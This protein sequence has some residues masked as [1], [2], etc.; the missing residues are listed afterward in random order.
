M[1]EQQDFQQSIAK[2]QRDWQGHTERK[3]LY[4]GLILMG[5]ILSVATLLAP[6][7]AAWL[8]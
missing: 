2:E 1:K 5:S 4:V 7:I 6:T 3:V 8:D